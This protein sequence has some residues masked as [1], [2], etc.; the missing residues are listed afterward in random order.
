MTPPQFIWIAAVLIMIVVVV[1]AVALV[2]RRGD[3]TNST[4]TGSSPAAIAKLAA[5]D[6]HSLLIDPANP[7]H[8]WF[9]SH[10]GLQES[11]DGGYTWRPGTLSNADAM[12][13][14]AS[15][16]DSA[17][18]YIAGH[19]VFNVSRDSGKTW[20]TT[21]GALP[22]SDIHAFA[23]NPKQPG[24]FFALF[25]DAGLFFSIDE[26][27]TWSELT[28][29]P[30]GEGPVALAANGEALYAA[31][32][33]GIQQS[34]DGGASWQPLPAQPAGRVISLAAP[35]TNPSLL[36]AGTD[37]GLFTSAD[38]GRSWSQLLA[39]G[40]GVMAVATAPSDPRRLLAVSGDARVF[41]SDDAGTTW[42][43]P[44]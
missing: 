11:R 5:P 15:A 39:N 3:E 43:A 1:A 35:E 13:M 17:T 21:R 37:Q 28:S 12:I 20:Q 8:V 34:R 18:I 6:V 42:R 31:T 36:Y 14:A 22:G 25:A 19:D 30:S 29:A 38:G 16:K 44:K 40:S 4:G 24:Q 2:N 33:A 41:R 26:G 10:A 7:D 23:Q 9:G 32:S 27:M